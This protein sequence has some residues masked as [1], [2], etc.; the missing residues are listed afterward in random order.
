[1]NPGDKVTFTIKRIS[2]RSIRFSVKVGV[3]VL[4]GQEYSKVKAGRKI[5][6][7]RSEGIRP[8]GQR[9]A[10]TDFLIPNAPAPAPEGGK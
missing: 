3:V 7:V 2:S 1:M 6:T 5:F 9:N 8:I 10:L 4:W